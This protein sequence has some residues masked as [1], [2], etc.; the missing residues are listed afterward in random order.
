MLFS[1][2]IQHDILLGK[3]VFTKWAY[4][5]SKNSAKKLTFA[6]TLEIWTEITFSAKQGRLYAKKISWKGFVVHSINWE[7]CE[8]YSSLKV[9]RKQQREL[10]KAPSGRLQPFISYRA[11]NANNRK[12][13]LPCVWVMCNASNIT[14]HISN[15]FRLIILRYIWKMCI[16]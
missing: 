10:D 8:Q 7:H 12:M 3:W 9:A 2:I 4:F 14:I 1:N 11:V 6:L 13:K 5:R 16:T 15:V